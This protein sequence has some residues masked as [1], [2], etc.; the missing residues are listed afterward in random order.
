[1]MDASQSLSLHTELFFFIFF[2]YV[3][4]FLGE[5]KNNNKSLPFVCVARVAFFFLKKR[6]RTIK[7]FFFVPRFTDAIPDLDENRK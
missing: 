2:P 3:S 1:M 6:E 4:F 5:K 7:F